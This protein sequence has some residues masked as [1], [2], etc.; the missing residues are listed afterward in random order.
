MPRR[1]HTPARRA[2]FNHQVH[3]SELWLQLRYVEPAGGWVAAAAAAAAAAGLSSEVATRGPSL[4]VASA[5]A[6]SEEVPWG[7]QEPL[8]IAE[9]EEKQQVA[10]HHHAALA[11]PP[12]TLASTLITRTLAPLGRWPSTTWPTP[13]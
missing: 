12:A 1:P 6:D 5:A 4:S 7:R 9:F 11:A 2:A 10:H 3:G 8:R 13:T